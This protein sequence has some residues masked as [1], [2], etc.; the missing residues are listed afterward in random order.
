MKAPCAGFASI[1]A[2]CI[3]PQSS[4]I[5]ASAY[6]FPEEA[7]ALRV[8]YKKGSYSLFTF[9]FFLYAK[10]E[11]KTGHPQEAFNAYCRF[12]CLML[13]DLAGYILP[14]GPDKACC[15]RV[16]NR[17]PKNL[18][19]DAIASDWGDERNIAQ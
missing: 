18:N 8:R 12:V 9:I 1:T 11:N 13:L 17:A 7:P 10:I 4:Q 16:A 14:D 6:L 15:R 3:A 5:P 19:P 2:R